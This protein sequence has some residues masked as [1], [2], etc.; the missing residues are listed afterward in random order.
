MDRTVLIIDDENQEEIFDRDIQGKLK[1]EGIEVNLVFIDMSSSDVRNED[2]TINIDSFEDKFTSDI[3]GKHIDIIACDYNFSD[4]SEVPKN[5][6]DV[7]DV[8]RRHRK[9][10]PIVLYSGNYNQI[11][12]EIFTDYKNN[13]RDQ[14][15]TVKRL[16]KIYNNHISKFVTRTEYHNEI[17]RILKSPPQNV[18][19][20]ILKELTA[21]GDYEFESAY[22]KFSGKKLQ[23]IANEIDK[24]THGGKE[25]LDEIVQQ[26]VG[27][28][29]NVNSKKEEE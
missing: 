23:E 1:R 20:M 13:V 29:I 22:P 24:N 18:E 10:T 19:Q 27:Y 7:I 21:Y 16:T 11:I 14:N 8:I 5:G 6:V 17:N 26:V 15:E 4:K 2:S 3:E 28:M 9:S 12:S 25:F